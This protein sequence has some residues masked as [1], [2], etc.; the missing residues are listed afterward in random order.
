MTNNE[1]KKG[2]LA[3]LL[4][5]ATA[6][7]APSRAA[8]QDSLGTTKEVINAQMISLGSA[9]L[10]DT[11]LSPEK[12][13]GI[14]LRYISHTL[15][16][17]P[18]RRWAHRITHYGV[19][20]SGD[21]RNEKGNLM[22]GLYTLDVAF[23]R[24]YDLLGGRLHLLAGGMTDINLGAVYNSRNQNNPAQIRMSM[25][26]GPTA[27]ARYDFDL[28]RRPFSIGY[29]LSVPILGLMFSPNYGQSYY[30]LF[31]RGN[32]EHN[33]VVTTPFNAPSLRQMLTLDFRLLGA[34]LR[35]GY[36][37]DIQQAKANHL[38]QH[39]YTHALIIGYV[40]NLRITHK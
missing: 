2:L 36:L 8:A 32:Y 17:T 9:N 23:I 16:F 29:E 21:D 20:A 15:R 11:Y 4:L 14:D 35:I 3:A 28:F 25:Q 40:K 24:Q 19:I 6:C 39:A 1:T 27:S 33:A 37:G 12:Y 26:I 34:R 18:G 30:E 38:K 31:S 7:L 13:N 10:L 22:Q 5:L